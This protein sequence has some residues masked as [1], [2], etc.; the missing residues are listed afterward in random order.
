MEDR[1]AWLT[2][3]HAHGLHAG[4]LQQWFVQRRA[5]VELADA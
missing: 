5:A 1:D 4:R 3:A 2:L